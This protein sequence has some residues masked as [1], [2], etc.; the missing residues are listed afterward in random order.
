MHHGK[1]LLIEDDHRLAKMVSQYLAQSGFECHHAATAALGL[2]QIQDDTPDL[3]VLD[4]MLPDMDGLEVCRRIRA[5][6]TAAATLPILM[7]TAKGDPMDRIVGLELGAV[8]YITKPLR[9]A[10]VRARVRTHLELKRAKAALKDENIYLEAE[11]ARTPEPVAAPVA[12]PA[13][14]PAATPV[15]SLEAAMERLAATGNPRAVPLPRPL[16]GSAEPHFSFAGLK[17]AVL[18]ARDAGV[19]PRTGDR[20]AGGAQARRCVARGGHRAGRAATGHIDLRLAA[21]PTGLPTGAGRRRQDGNNAHPGCR[22]SRFSVD[23]GKVDERPSVLIGQGTP[24][25]VRRTDAAR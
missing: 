13:S 17:S 2:A 22:L 6:P 4:L 25:D 21:R 5:L 1:L 14:A 24:L 12:A 19:R 3:L 16:L 10:I 8:D 11:V 15:A 7:L 18:R 23:Q 20:Q 9:P